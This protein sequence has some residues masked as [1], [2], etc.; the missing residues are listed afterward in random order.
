MWG[1]ERLVATLGR[2]RDRPC[3]TIVRELVSEVRTF[4][5]E[6]GPADDITVLI[7]RRLL[8]PVPGQSDLS[9]S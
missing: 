8:E 7:A 6:S 5:G 9:R 1:E 4:E 3:A 2:L